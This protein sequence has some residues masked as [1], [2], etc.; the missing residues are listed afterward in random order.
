MHME[1]KANIRQ[2]KLSSFREFVP[3]LVSLCFVFLFV[4]TG[5]DKLTHLEKFNAGISAVPYFGD[6]ADVISL[7]VPIGEIIIALLL[8]F[9]RTNNLGLKLATALMCIF[10]VYLTWMIGFADHKLCH[11]GGVIESLDW[12]SHLVFNIGFLIAGLW[13]YYLKNH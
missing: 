9:P 1:P 5:Y 12:T 13:A 11:C 4:Y 6:F 8:I 3:G 10:S 2:A 7:A